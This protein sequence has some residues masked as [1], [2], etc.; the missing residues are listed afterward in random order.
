[1]I[2]HNIDE[3]I[4]LIQR[5]EDNLLEQTQTEMD[6]HVP[7]EEQCLNI[8]AD[9]LVEEVLLPEKLVSSVEC[10]TD[11]VDVTQSLPFNIFLCNNHFENGCCSAEVQ[12]YFQAV[13][14]QPVI[15]PIA[16]KDMECQV[17]VEDLPKCTGF[18]G[19][20][21]IKDDQQL[22]D[23]CGVSTDIFTTLLE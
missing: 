5:F 18:H 16:K 3:S 1:M 10:Q 20:Q 19:Y 8:I 14:D 11:I 22:F 23:L 2:E 4:S 6:K 17:S 13:N 7:A 15:I 21:S 9:S 12:A